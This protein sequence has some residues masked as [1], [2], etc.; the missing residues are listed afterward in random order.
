MSRKPT[1]PAVLARLAAEG[2][3]RDGLRRGRPTPRHCR[4][5]GLVVLAA[6]DPDI[7]NRTQ[8][9]DALPVTAAGELAALLD[10]CESFQWLPLAPPEITYRGG[11][12]ISENHADKCAVLVTHLCGKRR[13]VN[14]SAAARMY[15]K[16]SVS[17]SAD[18]EPPF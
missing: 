15:P 12:D 9:L 11:H 4:H 3:Y 5:C 14:W 7:T 17:D 6:I 13:D 2:V 18:T 1:P 10:G 16:R 8:V